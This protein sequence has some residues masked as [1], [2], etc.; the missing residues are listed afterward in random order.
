MTEKNFQFFF[1]GDFLDAKILFTSRLS[2]KIWGIDPD[3]LAP[4]HGIAACHPDEVS[5][6]TSGWAKLIRLSNELYSGGEGP[7][8]VSVNMKMRNPSG[9][10][11]EILIQAYLFYSEIPHKTVYCLQVFT[12]IDSFK[13]HQSG[14]H[15][16]VGRDIS[17]FRYPD[18][19]LLETG[20]LFSKRQLQILRLIEQGMPSEKIAEKLF[21]SVHTV[22][23]HRSNILT[24]SG[25]DNIPDL[26]FEMK[27]SGLL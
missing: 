13:F 15:Y 20:I 6:N 18:Q 7:Y 21:I 10:Y 27:D 23:K 3:E 25:K 8:V 5:R 26:I 11:S 14:F 22:N 9:N 24:I 19:K 1:I 12:N 4:H 17:K 2:R 16:Y